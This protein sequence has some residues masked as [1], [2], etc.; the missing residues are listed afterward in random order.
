MR[1]PIFWILKGHKPV[2]CRSALEWALWCSTHEQDRFVKRDIIC[3]T[4]V[5]VSTIFV[6]INLDLHRG[7]PLLF[8]SMVFGGALDLT[9]QRYTTWAAAEAGHTVMLTNA[10]LSGVRVTPAETGVTLTCPGGTGSM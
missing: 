2:A 7:P 4:Q 1:T 6:G 3:D 10:Q 5:A 8:E 9:R